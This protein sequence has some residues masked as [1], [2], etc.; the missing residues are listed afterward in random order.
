MGD[1]R[2]LLAP[3]RDDNVYLPAHNARFAVSA[4]QK[5][6]ALVAM[7]GVDLAEILCIQV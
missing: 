3:D 5:G 4:E 7:S 2:S 1:P 6:S